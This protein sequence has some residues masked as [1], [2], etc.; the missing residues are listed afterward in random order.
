[1][2]YF[3]DVKYLNQI[4]YR[5]P[6]FAKKKQDLWNCRCIICG[7]SKKNK[8]KSRGYFYRNKNDLF[9]K[10]HNCAASQHFGTFLENLDSTLYKQYVFE[11]Y[12]SGMNGPK[13]HKNA[14]DDLV[15]EQPVFNTDPLKNVAERLDKLPDDNEAVVYCRNRNIP[16]KKFSELY[17]IPSVKDIVKIAPKYS[18]IKTEEPRL[19]LPFYDENENLVGVAMRAMRGE[20]LRY[21]NIK[22]NENA[23][24]IFGQDTV[25][26]TKTINIV[27][28]PIDSLFLDNSIAVAGTG[29][30]KIETLGYPEDK[31][32]V[33]FDNQPRNTQ[34]C[35][36][37]EKYIN[38]NY[39]V[40][41]WPC[42]VIEK[43]INDMVTAGHDVESLIRENT[44]QGLM[45]KLKFTEWRNC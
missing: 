7:D 31:I 28:G 21:I 34:V 19:L 27:E 43:D 1:M 3:I 29:F 44:Y 42:D 20:N 38:L 40:C 2:S 22:L 12:S 35:D 6:N 15:F 24:L 16:E 23:T 14:E 17:F 36:L 39:Q 11:R 4:G 10:C 45:A 37:V 25:D 30:N 18:S 26:R 41:I 13:A 33:V 5:L 8:N 9:Y 32:V